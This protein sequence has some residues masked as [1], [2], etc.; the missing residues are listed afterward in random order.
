MTVLAVGT[1]SA[2]PVSQFG[3]LAVQGFQPGQGRG[4]VG[5]RPAHRGDQGG[6]LGEPLADRGEVG[7]FTVIELGELLAVG[8]ELVEDG[9]QRIGGHGRP[10]RDEAPAAAEGQAAAASSGMSGRGSAAG[11]IC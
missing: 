1:W 10:H 9:G 11:R 7:G 4:V 3:D 8:G 5:E 2:E 6:E